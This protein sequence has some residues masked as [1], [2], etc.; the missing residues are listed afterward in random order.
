MDRGSLCKDLRHEFVSPLMIYAYY[1][2]N[3]DR[4]SID[5]SPDLGLP[6]FPGDRAKFTLAQASCPY[7]PIPIGGLSHHLLS[8]INSFWLRN[9]DDPITSTVYLRD[10]D[11]PDLVTQ[12]A[13]NRRSREMTPTNIGRGM[14]KIAV[15]IFTE[16][17]PS[18]AFAF[19]WLSYT[20]LQGTTKTAILPNPPSNLVTL[21]DGNAPTARTHFTGTSIPSKYWLALVATVF[22][23]FWT[24]SAGDPIG[25]AIRGEPSVTFA[26]KDTP[27]RLE[28]HHLA[29]W[30]PDG[31]DI[32]WGDLA[33]RMLRMLQ[34]PAYLSK[35]ETLQSDFYVEDKQIA[36]ITI[37]KIDD[38]TRNSSRTFQTG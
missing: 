33:S 2:L 29:I 23:T 38:E 1:L 35:W 10:A 19:K 16:E 5:L 13:V 7:Q 28:L 11:F 8:L 18:K 22:D 17:L 27:W 3:K 24:C 34:L 36:T 30:N 14:N 15:Q 4:T 9:D 6:L 37:Y 26:V 20:H 12:I 21:G 32:V 25:P 31:S